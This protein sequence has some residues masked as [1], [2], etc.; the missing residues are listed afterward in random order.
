MEDLD[1][2]RQQSEKQCRTTVVLAAVL[3]AAGTLIA[4]LEPFLQSIA[5]DQ[6]AEE[7]PKPK[8]A[9]SQGEKS[10]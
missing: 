4:A 1:E 9:R 5:L 8:M 10:V 7:E 3:A 2:W 6:A